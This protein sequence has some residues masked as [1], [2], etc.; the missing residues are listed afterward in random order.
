MGDWE[1]E[2]GGASKPL[3]LSPSY[4]RV[5]PFFASKIDILFLPFPQGKW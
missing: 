3:F 1:E 4:S 5:S 2:E